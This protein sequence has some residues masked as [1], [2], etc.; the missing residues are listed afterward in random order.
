MWTLWILTSFHPPSHVTF[1]VTCIK[2]NSQLRYETLS[3][4]S[5]H[6]CLYFDVSL[7]MCHS[8]HVHTRYRRLRKIGAKMP[9]VSN[10]SPTTAIGSDTKKFNL[11][12]VHVQCDVTHLT[13]TR[14]R[15][16]WFPGRKWTASRLRKRGKKLVVDL[17]QIVT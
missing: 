13:C 15:E 2:L 10:I 12:C 14:D 7:D 1:A 3:T 11:K 5:S 16:G 17:Q 9:P 8:P 4:L 6:G